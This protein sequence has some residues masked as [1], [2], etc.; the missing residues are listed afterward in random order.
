[1]SY[2][3]DTTASKERIWELW[4]DVENWK[5][6]DE[7]LEYSDLV[8]GQ[9]FGEGAVGYMKGTGAPRTRFRIE[10]VQP[11]ESFSV[12]LFLPLAQSLELQRFFETTED[13][14]TRFTHVVEF[15]GFLKPV[16]YLF[17]SRAFKSDLIKVVD[18]IQE[19]ADEGAATP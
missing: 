9:P 1:M 18:S 13:D 10:N 17:I 8:D 6:F 11:M 15:Q 2:S 5:Q 3:A 12:R 16:T 19:I 7:R 14:H 4:T